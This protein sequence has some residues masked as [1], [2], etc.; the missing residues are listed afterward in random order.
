M[1][2]ENKNNELF[3][4]IRKS[5]STIDFDPNKLFS[6]NLREETSSNL[7]DNDNLSSTKEVTSVSLE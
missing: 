3:D 6:T 7:A 1:L 4:E 5:L 2:E